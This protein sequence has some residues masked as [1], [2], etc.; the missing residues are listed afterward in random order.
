MQLSRKAPKDAMAKKWAAAKV[1][2]PFRIQARE[3]AEGDDDFLY[4][5]NYDEM[6]FTCEVC[7]G[8]SN[9]Q[10]MDIVP[11]TGSSNFWV[12]DESA[13]C[14]QASYVKSSSNSFKES[15]GEEYSIQYGSG[16]CKGYIG[17]ETVKWGGYTLDSQKVGF[18]TEAQTFCGL[19]LSGILGL[20]FRAISENNIDPVFDVITKQEGLQAL[21]EKNY[22]PSSHYSLFSFYLSNDEHSESSHLHLGQLDAGCFEGEVSDLKWV[23]LSSETYWAINV[24]DITLGGEAMEAFKPAFIS[25]MKNVTLVSMTGDEEEE[26]DD[27]IHLCKGASCV[28]IVDSGTSLLTGPSEVV[29]MINQFILQQNPDGTVDCDRTDFPTINVHIGGHQFELTKEDYLIK[30]QGRCFSGLMGMDMPQSQRPFWIM[31]DVFM[32]KH[33]TVYDYGNKRVGFA[34]AK[35]S[36]N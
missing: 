27:D 23:P 9:E 24:E 13:K 35:T 10:C 8:D 11:D 34:T 5:K 36:C 14:P 33:Y 3:Q 16:E 28:A 12:I 25:A 1:A 7:L 15:E 21:N 17:Y 30:E 20:A 29:N 31:G 22:S 18:A 6:V 32:R 26:G 4:L 19:E 2:T